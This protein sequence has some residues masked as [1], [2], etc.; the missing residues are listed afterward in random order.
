MPTAQTLKQQYHSMRDLL[1]RYRLLRE[2]HLRYLV[3]C[4]VIRPVVRTNADTFFAF[5]DLAIIK[6]ANDELAARRRSARSPAI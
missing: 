4:G 6:Q 1:A 2:D 3:K 5:A